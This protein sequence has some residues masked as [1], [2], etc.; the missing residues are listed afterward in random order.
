MKQIKSI[1]DKY[2]KRLDL[3][4][5][6]IDFKFVQFNRADGFPQKG[7]IKV[8]LKNKRATIL[9]REENKNIEQT[10]VHELVHLFLWDLD[11]YAEKN[12]PKNKKDPYFEKLEYT[13]SKITK[14]ILKTGGCY[15]TN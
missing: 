9:L 3:N 13:V 8:T 1:I 7:D 5:W 6:M 4:D 12:I 14:I 15:E 11:I 2:Q 10:I